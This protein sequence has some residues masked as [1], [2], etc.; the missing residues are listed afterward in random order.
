MLTRGS[1]NSNAAGEPSQGIIQEEK[2]LMGIFA[3][4]AAAFLFVFW[5]VA[6]VALPATDVMNILTDTAAL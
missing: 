5:T 6:S 1:R 4:I 2:N 3:F